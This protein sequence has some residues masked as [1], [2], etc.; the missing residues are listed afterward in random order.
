MS[1]SDLRNHPAFSRKWMPRLS[2]LAVAAL[3]LTL[4][5]ASGTA[6]A[7]GAVTAPIT[8][9]SI[10]GKVQTAA[11]QSLAV[12]NA[13]VTAVLLDGSTATSAQTDASGA[14]S[15]TGLSAGTYTLQFLPSYGGV[16][17]QQWWNAKLDRSSAT[18]FAVSAG[19][20]KIG[21]NATLAVGASISG[22]VQSSVSPFAPL[23]GAMVELSQQA[24][25]D[26]GSATTDSFGRYTAR[27]LSAGIYV[28]Q[29]MPPWGSN[30]LSQSW[31][32]GG[33]VSPPGTGTGIPVTTGLAVTGIN[34]RLLTGA[35]I[36]GHIQNSA[37]IGIPQVAVNALSATVNGPTL[38]SAS[39]DSA[40][41][42][43][44]IAVAAAA[45]VTLQ[46]WSSSYTPQFWGNKP[47]L[48]AAT[49]FGVAN[50]QARSGMNMTLVPGASISGTIH[51]GSISGPAVST[52]VAAMS[53]STLQATSVM[54]DSNG[55][56]SLQSLAPGTYR[57]QASSTWQGGLAGIWWPAAPQFAG[58][59]PITVA[60]QQ[61]VSG[62]TM[63]MDVG[64]TVSGTVT[65]PGQP[66]TA[67]PS[68]GVAGVEVDL[69]PNDGSPFSAAFT[70]YA[71]NYTITGITPGTYTVHYIKPY[72]LTYAY[73]WYGQS[74]AQ[75]GA[76][77]LMIKK[78]QTL[79]GINALLPLAIFSTGNGVINGSALVGTR[80]TLNSGIWLPTATTLTFRWARNGV[81][82]AGATANN[83]LLTPADV[84]TTLTATITG[85]KASYLP[86][87]MTTPATAKVVAAKP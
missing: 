18:Y 39:T 7:T 81:T 30:L 87:T 55:N 63:V 84:G 25:D 12:Q 48:A 56:F 83:Y 69:V 17:A 34:T 46:T 79:T 40:G 22:I 1:A 64:A 65:A 32:D 20:A 67:L 31:Q 35:T 27:G 29:V 38:G 68:A 28:E 71:G 53:T 16:L 36:T 10:S 6:T 66:G 70:N 51:S 61:A 52:I 23:A 73:L 9:A 13:M 85:T 57:I 43:T 41:N 72:W 11:P 50:G 62:I 26:S 44:I 75:T 47:T 59:T 77:N 78:G 42:F 15:I 82:I 4:T 49:F 80:L 37:G 24:G 3:T 19:Q 14:Y 2:L 45:Q 76:T 21:F 5:F 54:T 58:A 60:G 86:A 8:S 74:L 33:V